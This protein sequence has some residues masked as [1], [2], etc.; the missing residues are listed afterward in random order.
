MQ[1]KTPDAPEN[2][3]YA[4]REF[5]YGGCASGVRT[6]RS[7]VGVII[8]WVQD[9]WPVTAPIVTQNKVAADSLAGLEGEWAAIVFW[10]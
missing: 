5:L 1:P 6:R 7:Y 8:V 4:F 9:K 10:E 3:S 2:H